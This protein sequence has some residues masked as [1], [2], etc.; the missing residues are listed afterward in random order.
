MSGTRRGLTVLDT[1]YWQYYAK[2]ALRIKTSVL[3]EQNLQIWD[4]KKYS[5][6]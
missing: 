1:I 6:P 5:I 2:T 3:R 4:F